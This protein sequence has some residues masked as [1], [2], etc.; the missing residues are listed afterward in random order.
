MKLKLSKLKEGDTVL[1][2]KLVEDRKSPRCGCMD[3]GTT[4]TIPPGCFG[5]GYEWPR[6]TDGNKG[7]ICLL[8][9]QIFEKEAEVD[10]VMAGVSY[11]T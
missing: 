10:C 2:L 11:K 1:V 8:G 4:M 5:V 6:D 3:P 9:N 7:K